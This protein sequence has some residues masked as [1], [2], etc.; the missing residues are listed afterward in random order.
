MTE[1][2]RRVYRVAALMI[3]F[4]VTGLMALPYRFG[5]WR[6]IKGVGKITMLWGSGIAK[7]QNI[8]L[9]VHGEIPKSF[10][11]GLIVST[12]SGYLDIIAHSA[13]FP[14]RFTPKIEIARWPLL[15]PFLGLSRPIWIDRGSK[16]KSMGNVALFRETMRRGIP[17]I[18]YPEGTTNDGSKVLPFKT[19]PFEAAVEGGFKILPILTVL[20]GCPGRPPV[21]WHGSMS[22]LP[23]IWLILSYPET[24]IDMYIL[25]VA[26]P[27]G[28]SRKDIARELYEIMSA[29]FERIK[30]RIPSAAA[31]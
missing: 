16:Q 15:G 29:E 6:A 31:Q 1:L 27:S 3:W 4:C 24:Y 11:G 28:K 23:H 26:D 7:I 9:A 8:K 25:P 14:I 12:H 20:R 30:G 19:S 18:V 10:K 22:L 5:G 17:L 21:T 13:V 2:C